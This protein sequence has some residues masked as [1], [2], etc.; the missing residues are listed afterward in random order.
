MVTVFAKTTPGSLFIA[1]K[2]AQ[3]GWIGLSLTSAEFASGTDL[4]VGRRPGFIQAATLQAVTHA[5]RQ[6]DL[7]PVQLLR[8]AGLTPTPTAPSD[9]CIPAP[10][11]ARL[12]RAG[13]QASS[14]PDF[15]LVV[16]LAYQ[17]LMLAR[18][19]FSTQAPGTIG[20]G[21]E[22]FERHL[23]NW[24]NA[25]SI[26]LEHLQDAVIV[27]LGFLDPVAE[28]DALTMDL[29]MGL[30]LRML[31]WVLGESWWPDL[32]CFTRSRPADVAPHRR[33]FGQMAFDHG[34]NGLIINAKRLDQP[35]VLPPPSLALLIARYAANNAV[36][37][38]AGAAG[39]VRELIARLLPTGHCTIDRVAH[40]LGVDRRTIHRRLA[41]EGHS[42]TQLI[43]QTRRDMIADQI[44]DRTRSL[45]F[46]ADLLGFS[47]LSTFSRWH[48]TAF[49]VAARDYRRTGL[50]G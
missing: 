25:P 47:S 14:R 23:K 31:R 18:P 4:R 1:R 7:D 29:C 13:A 30:G 19:D 17:S 33:L 46:I 26:K 3:G 50:S 44:G 11:L 40:H 39:E 6:L 43:D 5:A 49:G 37:G 42:F 27:R 16:A 20:D 22:A 2:H 36:Q 21:L 38:A 8:Q 9:A 12:L 28:G 10:A 41:A 48:R 15:P 24:R 34:F 35:V 32:A 45:S